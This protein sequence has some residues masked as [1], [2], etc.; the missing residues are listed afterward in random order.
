[1]SKEF[2]RLLKT[3]LPILARSFKIS[4]FR[5]VIWR[6]CWWWK[7]FLRWSQ[8]YLTCGPQCLVY[9]VHSWLKSQFREM[10]CCHCLLRNVD[11]SLVCFHFVAKNSSNFRTWMINNQCHKGIFMLKLADLLAQIMRLDWSG[12]YNM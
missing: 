2:I 1:M 10:A 4:I 3:E 7:I 5:I 8:L 11:I 6:I 12:D 9:S